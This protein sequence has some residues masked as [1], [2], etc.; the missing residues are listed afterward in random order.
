MPMATCASLSTFHVNAVKAFHHTRDSVGLY[1]IR[2]AVLLGMRPRGV[3]RES[4]N[5]SKEYTA[6]VFTVDD[7]STLNMERVMPLKR[8]Q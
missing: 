5:I 3:V 2:V 7:I 4:T 6:S 8:R 1:K